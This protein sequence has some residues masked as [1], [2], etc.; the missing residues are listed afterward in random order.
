MPSITISFDNDLISSV[1]KRAKKLFLSRKE[2][3]E[4]IVRRSMISYTKRNKTKTK[5]KVDDKLVGIFSRQRSGRKKKV[6][7]KKSEKKRI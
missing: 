1:D 5:I 7:K 4:D 3:V 2:L 6:N